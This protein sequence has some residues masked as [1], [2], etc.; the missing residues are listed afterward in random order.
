MEEEVVVVRNG[1]PLLRTKQSSTWRKCKLSNKAVTTVAIRIQ[2]EV[3]RGEVEW[4]KLNR[5]MYLHQLESILLKMTSSL[6]RIISSVTRR[7]LNGTSRA[8]ADNSR[9]SSLCLAHYSSSN[10][11]SQWNS[12][13]CL[14]QGIQGC[15]SL[16]RSDTLY[17]WWR[18][19][20][21]N[22]LM[23]TRHRLYKVNDTQKVYRSEMMNQVVKGRHYQIW[24]IR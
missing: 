4:T 19:K 17:C 16:L 22:G 14:I 23:S 6:L 24:N 8:R 9:H 3:D 11:Y 5:Y 12:L 2:V 20:G 1:S 10:G 15:L 13:P 18:W 21:D 7:K